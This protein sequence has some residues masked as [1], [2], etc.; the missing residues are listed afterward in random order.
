MNNEEFETFKKVF[1]NHFLAIDRDFFNLNQYIELVEDND[2]TYSVKLMSL[3]MIICSEID[4]IG[5]A[6]ARKS[7]NKLKDDCDITEWFYYIQN[8]C[9]VINF[10][11][12]SLLNREDKKEF[13]IDEFEVNFLGNR[14]II[15][16]K[17]FK[18]CKKKNSKNKVYFEWEY[19]EDMF[20]WWKNH[21][22]VKHKR[23]ELDKNGNM[24]YRKASLGNVIYAFSALYVLELAYAKYVCIPEEMGFNDASHIF[25]NGSNIEYMS[26]NDLQSMIGSIDC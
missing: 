4:S 16:W 1:W 19:K 22:D 23:T 17:N 14:K 6:L 20:E 10:D 2:K 13:K 7:T 18:S 21:N 26:F 3:Y 5:K 8:K 9:T 11:D 25:G 15:P 24:N 12:M